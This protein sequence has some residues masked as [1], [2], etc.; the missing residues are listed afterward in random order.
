MPTLTEAI[1]VKQ[2]IKGIR[3]EITVVKSFWVISAKAGHSVLGESQ[4][5]R[6]S[7]LLVVSGI[8]RL[9]TN[10]QRPSSI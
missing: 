3:S 9:T 10:D 5:R 4:Q 8:Y 6:W 2:R 1:T 7:V